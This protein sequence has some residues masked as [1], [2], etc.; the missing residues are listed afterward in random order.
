MIV[1]F[2][3]YEADSVSGAL[4][5]GSRRIGADEDPDNDEKE[6]LT[7]MKKKVALIA[8]AS[9]IS[10]SGITQYLSGS[11]D[12]EVIGLARKTLEETGRVRYIGVNL[13]DRTDCQDKLSGLTDVTHLFYTA[14]LEQPTER[15]QVAINGGMLRNAVEVMEATAPGLEHIS[16]MEGTKTY[17]CQFGPFKTP[18]KETGPRHMPPNFYFDQEDYLRERQIGKKW[19]WSALR[20]ALVMGPGVGHPMNLSMVI[21]VYAAISK[22]LG[23]PLWFPGTLGGYSILCEATDNVHLGRAAVWAATE[24]RCGNEV[25]NITNGDCFRWKNIWPRIAEFFDIAPGPPLA[26]PLTETMADK[27]PI[28]DRIVKKYSLTPHAYDQIASWQFG[29]FVFRI[30]YDLISDT[31]KARL[32]GFHD[33]VETEAMFMR[34]FQDL[35]RARYIP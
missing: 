31:T 11:D 30:D 35:R 9:G 21:A 28:W 13:L 26:I 6:S 1:P 29:E 32:F 24:P 22:E 27:G 12:W 25:F 5:S 10:G 16:L 34:L 33:V 14:Y 20:P 4:G 23:L 19:K 8:G 18:A 2:G 7:T 3:P 17:G 15:E